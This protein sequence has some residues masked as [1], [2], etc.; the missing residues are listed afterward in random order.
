MNGMDLFVLAADRDMANALEGLLSRSGD[1][2]IRDVAFDVR[3]H[4]DRDSG[5]RTGSVEHLR[6]YLNRYDHALIVF[7]RHGCGDDRPRQDIQRYVEDGLA[8]NGWERRAKAIVI[9]PELEAWTWS[10][11]PAVSRI[12][13]WGDQYSALRRWLESQKLWPRGRSKPPDPKKAMRK[14]MQNKRV[15]RSSRQF[16]GLAKD[17]DFNGCQDPAFNELRQTLQAWFPPVAAA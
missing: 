15:R 2:G 4:P 3:R 16:S 17:V 6:P 10:T 13:G 12:L 11:S 5:C 8:R 1:L 14:A 7:D 9:D